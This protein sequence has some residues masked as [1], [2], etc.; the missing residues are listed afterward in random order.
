[1]G[2]RGTY[3]SKRTWYGKR[4]GIKKGGRK[5]RERVGENLGL[6]EIVLN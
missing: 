1:V 2:R 5:G 4:R 3:V 6:E